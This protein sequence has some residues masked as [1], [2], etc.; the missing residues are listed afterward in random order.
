MARKELWNQVKALK[1]KN[2]CVTI[3]IEILL[4]LIGVMIDFAAIDDKNLVV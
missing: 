4:C 2:R 3:I 1:K